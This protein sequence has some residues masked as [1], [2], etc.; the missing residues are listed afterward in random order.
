[1]ED[2]VEEL[3]GEIWDEHDEAVEPIMK[4]GNG[5][6]R[7]M[8]NISLPALF[9]FISAES[10]SKRENAAGPA[11]S[12]AADDAEIPNISVGSWTL[13]NL[14]G[15]PRTGDEFTS[16]GLRVTVSKVKRHRVFEAVVKPL[17]ACAGN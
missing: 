14:G 4:A 17:S 3:V 10:N 13:E 8:G 15:L 5:S 12:A 9:E 6:F 16:L 1:M 2:I 7:V 11:D